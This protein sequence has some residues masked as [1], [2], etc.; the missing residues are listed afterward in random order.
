M[1]C[2]KLSNE[3]ALLNRAFVYTV[4]N[5]LHAPQAR[6]RVVRG[7]NCCFGQTKRLPRGQTRVQ[8]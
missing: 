7:R 4:Q 6:A 3:T 5:L 1:H 8:R 2:I